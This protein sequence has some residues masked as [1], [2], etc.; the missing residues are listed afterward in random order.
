M[1]EGHTLHRLA[2]DHRK[3]LDGVRVRSSSPQGRFADEARELDGQRVDAVEAYGKH[4]FYRF[5]S[6]AHVH[7]HLGLYGR[8]RRWRQPALPPRGAIRWRVETSDVCLDLSGPTA[9]ELLDQAQVA[10]IQH[11]LGPDLLRPDARAA[12]AWRRLSGS[13]RALGAL[14]L[15][16]SVMSG[17][18]NVYRA[19]GLFVAGLHPELRGDELERRDFTRLWKTLRAQLRQG[20]KDR[21]IVTVPHPEGRRAR[22]GERTWVYGQRVCRRCDGPIRRWEL[23]QRT[24]YACE[25]CQRR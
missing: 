14:L 9:C 5:E 11:R 13:R 22:K 6:G 23:G 8:F 1:P 7:V 2:L 21:R 19:E 25:A 17:V 24:M 10:A 18:G 15:D 12:E 3:V 4:L 20:V 16:Q